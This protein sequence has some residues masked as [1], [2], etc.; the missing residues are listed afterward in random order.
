M[1]ILNKTVPQG[2]GILTLFFVRSGKHHP[3]HN[4]IWR[5]DDRSTPFSQGWSVERRRIGAWRGV[6]E[7]ILKFL[8]SLNS[9]RE[10]KPTVLCYEGK[11]SGKASYPGR[12]KQSAVGCFFFS[13]FSAKCEAM[14][15]P[16]NQQ[17]GICVQSKQA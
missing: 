6:R 8:L 3:K 5:D 13:F 17:T 9:S 10:A 15:K 14:R 12:W 1:E 7:N 2:G 11:A 16:G 4:L